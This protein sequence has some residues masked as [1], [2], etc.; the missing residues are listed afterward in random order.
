MLTYD[1]LWA[2]P[3]IDLHRHLEGSLR[4]ST[5]V[6]I[7]KAYNLDVPKQIESLRP[8]VQ[9]TNDPPN[10]FTFLAKFEMLRQFYRSPEMIQRLVYEA[11]ED[12]ANDNIQYLE[13]RFSP[14]ALS[15]VRGFALTAVTDWVIE[16]VNKACRDYRIDVRLIVTLVRHNS[17][18]QAKQVAEIAF[19]RIDRGIVG[20]DLAGDEIN[21]P[22]EP[23][24]PIF[25][26]AKKLGMGITVH[27][28]EWMGADTVRHAIENLGATRIGHGT[29]TH[30]DPSVLSLVRERNVSLEVCLTSNVQT[31]SVKKIKEHP[32]RKFLNL[33]IPVTLNTDD[34]SISDIN[35]SHEFNVAVREAKLTYDDLR[36]MT[37][38]AIETAY[39]KPEEK[40]VLRQHYEQY[41]PVTI[42]ER[43]P[44][45]TVVPSPQIA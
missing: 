6:D 43:M 34:P 16:A 27:A 35:L 42:S 33:N 26:E 3:K 45:P 31:A 8:H 44:L 38:T 15:R 39:L 7:A 18:E 23:F 14:Q 41:W 5:L 17:L 25:N 20:L 12:A 1:Q 22:A 19:D 32:L 30:E 36:R 40:A 24:A 9:V 37:F 21:H 10:A 2:I 28:G 29:R 11:V 4:L 13:L